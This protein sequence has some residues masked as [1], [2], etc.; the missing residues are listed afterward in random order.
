MGRLIGIDYGQ[1]RTGLAVTDPSRIMASQL[2][3]IGSY[4]VYTWL[5]KYM[6]SETVDGFV[7]GFPRDMRNQPSQSARFVQ[8]FVK[9]LKN[10]FPSIP[11]YWVDERFTSTMAVQSMVQAGV[12][13]SKRK[14][15]GMVDAL[16]AVIILESYLDQE[17]NKLQQP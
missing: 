10:K 12:P 8:D 5:A 15:K 13:K 11:V 1:K 6:A 2:A 3:S 17:K 9:G 14:D 16:S 7:V 4:D